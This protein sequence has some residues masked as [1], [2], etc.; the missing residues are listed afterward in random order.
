M[1]FRFREEI[2]ANIERAESSRKAAAELATKGYSDF[3]A[4][5]A[6]YAAFYAATALLLSREREFSKHSGIIAAIH[7]HFVKT[8]VLSQEHGKNLN[9]LF[10]LRDIGDYGTTVHV[11]QEDAKQAV[12]AAQLFIE[13]V[14]SLLTENE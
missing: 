6:Y 10:E 12:H 14:K 9:W 11:P 3:S 5:R 4:S 8:G 2:L 1:T 7:K 13:A